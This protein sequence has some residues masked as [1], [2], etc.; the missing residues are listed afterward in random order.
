MHDSPS[1]EALLAAI[2]DTLVDQ[3]LP[4]TEGGTRHAVRVAAN[5]C[6]IVIREL[7][8]PSGDEVDAALAALVR[9]EE[10]DDLATALD[11]RLKEADPAF[12][13][14]VFDLLVADT[15]R[16]VDVAKPGYSDAGP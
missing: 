12:D 7:E 10:G 8:A 4:T 1:A 11:E 5:L 6:R 16:R 13:A 2:A 15:K 3:V 14:R 9:I